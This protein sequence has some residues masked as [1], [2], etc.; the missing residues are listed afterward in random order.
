MQSA[1]L[2]QTRSKEEEERGMTCILGILPRQERLTGC[3]SYS[4][5]NTTGDPATPAGG[6]APVV[7]WCPTGGLGTFTIAERG[8]RHQ[9]VQDK[10][11]RTPAT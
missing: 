7:V 9:H 10:S 1:D 2:R 3:A 5:C 6:A 11:Y 8:S 4:V